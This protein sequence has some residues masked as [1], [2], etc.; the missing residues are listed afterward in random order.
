M[1]ETLRTGFTLCHGKDLGEEAFAR[2][3]YACVSACL[4]ACFI[5]HS[6]QWGL[7]I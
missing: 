6:F 3:V 2:G 5:I 4:S 7:T 1:L